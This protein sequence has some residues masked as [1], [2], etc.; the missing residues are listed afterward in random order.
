MAY[1]KT[2]N[3]NQDKDVKYLSKDY[4]SFKQQLLEFAKVYFPDNFNDF[5]ESNPAMMFLE[6]AAYVGD[7]LSFYTDTQLKESF[8]SLAQD[9]ENLYNLAHAMGYKPNTTT[10]SSVNLEITQLVPANASNNYEPDYDYALN[11]DKDSTFI[12][13]EGST[14]YTTKATRFGFSSSFEPTT[15]DPYQYDSD[16]NIE[17]WLLKKTI[18]AVSGDTKTKKFTIGSA[19]SFQTLNLFDTNIISIESIT[20]SENNIWYEVPYLAQDTIYEEVE[21]IGTNDPSLLQHSSQTPYLLKLKKVPRR[22]ITRVKSDNSIDIQFGTGT[23][24][25]ADEEVIPNPDNI[26]FGI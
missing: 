21:N 18:P 26:G 5:S 3:K 9:K 15:K 2:S 14:F 23:L 25:K 19:E 22:F 12:S 4:N 13:T 7:V 11:L 10:A 16:N 1:T 17:Y 24:G 8:L 20:D 6:M